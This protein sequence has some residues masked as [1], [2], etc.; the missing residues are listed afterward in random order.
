MVEIESLLSELLDVKL[1]KRTVSHLRSQCRLVGPANRDDFVSSVL[2][3]CLEA[4][5]QQSDMDDNAVFRAIDRVGHRI[6]RELRHKTI[7]FL[8]EQADLRA[9]A[10]AETPDVAALHDALAILSPFDLKIIQSHFLEGESANSLASRFGIPR[11]TFYRRMAE[12][13]RSLKRA[14]SSRL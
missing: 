2:L 5:R 13:K 4:Q 6:R 11:R 12:L 10:R 1:S 14:I 8:P 9:K 3:E 7:E